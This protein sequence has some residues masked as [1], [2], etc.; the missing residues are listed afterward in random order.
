MDSSAKSPDAYNVIWDSPSENQ[1]GSMPIGNGDLASNIWVE[2]NGD[3]LILLAKSDALDACA[4]P[5]KLGQLRIRMEPS[6]V[7][8]ATPFTQELNL[9]SGTI[10]IRSAGAE[11]DIWFDA[12]NPAAHVEITS[13]SPR[14]VSVIHETWRNETTR[15][16]KKDSASFFGVVDRD[17][18][19]DWKGRAPII[20]KDTILS[21]S[22]GR[23]TFYHR[24]GYSVWKDNMEA[25]HLEKWLH[26]ACD[27]LL[28][29]TFGA[30]VA[31]EGMR[32][33]NDQHIE[34]TRP[35]TSLAL[36]ITAH[37]SITPTPQEWV[38]KLDETARV[39]GSKSLSEARRKHE[40]WWQEFWCRGWIHIT[41][42]SD[43]TP[44]VNFDKKGSAF[45]VSRGYALQRWI[46]ACA[47]R[48]AYP[49]KFNGSLFTV[50]NCD[51]WMFQE[52]K[53]DEHDQDYRRWGQCYWW[54][55][56]RLPYWSMLATGDFDMIM[57]LFDMYVQAVPLRKFNT[58][59]FYGHDGI[60]FN[61]TIFPWG[62]L[63]N[64]DYGTGEYRKGKP[65]GSTKTPHIEYYW[66]CGI[67]LG[68]MMFDYAEYTGDLT[69]LKE[70]ILPF[71]H[72]IVTFYDKHYKRDKDGK[73][74]ISPANALED[75]WLGKNPA[76][77]IAG[78]R[79]MLTALLHHF[80]EGE[81]HDQYAALLNELPQLPV[82]EAENGEKIL[83]PEASGKKRRGNTENPELYSVFPYRIFGVGKPGLS[84]VRETFKHAP[85]HYGDMVRYPM[86][87]N[88][89]FIFKACMG[90]SDASKKDAVRHAE[91]KD[92]GSR[93][94]G[95]WQANFDW[96]PDQDHGGVL[97]TGLQ[98]MLMQTAAPYSDKTIYLLPAWPND[99][100]VDFKLHA[101]QNT[102]IEGS[103]KNGKI[104]NLKV[105]PESRRKDIVIK[106]VSEK[107]SCPK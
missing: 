64:L 55:N 67:E 63:T 102:V 74:D 52:Y 76:P 49:I 25:L 72:E 78:L 82:A 27:P 107:H 59:L 48:G 42:N 31:A 89:D 101:P 86:G 21:G 37:T 95:F 75:V 8:P 98:K 17:T 96:I 35:V 50:K 77:D 18:G 46:S 57:P 53:G 16:E 13:D 30:I 44:D 87:W 5:V 4:R 81:K 60:Y 51:G 97:M 26:E 1:H 58:R 54:Q 7:L 14:K 61:E 10:E 47:G 6:L 92:P 84:M 106:K 71:V 41:E 56:T 100:D 73:L 45:V 39:V 2:P 38:N 34:T 68:T 103:F 24:N 91:A 36:N 43:E 105:T 80:P 40:K 66:H 93:F 29:R 62:T 15:L 104:V 32:N 90:M 28:N 65:L 85:K 79:V 83:V 20:E 19:L 11:L 12:N 69:Y 9:K 94:P 23:I 22:D 33:I 3:I 99:W 88:Q 70:T